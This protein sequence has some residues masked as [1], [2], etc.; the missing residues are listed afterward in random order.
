MTILHNT[1]LPKP[2]IVLV[3][4]PQKTSICFRVKTFTEYDC[5]PMPIPAKMANYRMEFIILKAHSQSRSK[6]GGSILECQCCF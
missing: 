3:P 6:S 4:H 2:Q 1:L 5:I